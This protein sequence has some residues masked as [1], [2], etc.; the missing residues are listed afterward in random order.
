MTMLILAAL[1]WVAIHVGI[2]GTALRGRLV[3]SMG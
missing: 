3:A 2:S 1:L